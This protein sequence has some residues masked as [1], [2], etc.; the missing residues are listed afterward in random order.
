MD[1]NRIEFVHPEAFY[2]LTSLQFVTLEGNLLQQLH[3]DTFI[4][5]RH[6]Q[7]FK[8]SSIKTIYLSDNMLASLPATL[9]TGCYQLE[10]IFLNG[11]PW[12][13]DCRMDWIAAW[14]GKNPG[15]DDRAVLHGYYV[16]N[17]SGIHLAH[18]IGRKILVRII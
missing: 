8:I 9:F 11:N 7:I 18:I 15:R 10:N 17:L 13:C 4:T 1:H 16:M 2:G 5:L 6:S 3:P 12:S 14:I